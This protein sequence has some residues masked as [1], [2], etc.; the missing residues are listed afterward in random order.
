MTED[1]RPVLAAED[2]ESDA[3]ILRLAFQRAQLPCPLV[4][5]RDGQ[6]VVDY[7]IGN[8]VYADRRIH[9]L[10]AS[11]VLDL[12]MPRMDGFDVLTWLAMQPDFREIPTVVLSSSPDPS[13]IESIS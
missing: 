10:P 8:G 6:E 1:L 9:P 5:V 11:I 4:I 12:K 2:E 13:D 3:M 7:L